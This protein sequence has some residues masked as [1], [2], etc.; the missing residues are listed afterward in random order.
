MPVPEPA[1]PKPHIQ[2]IPFIFGALFVVF[3]VLTDT[4]K[5]LKPIFGYQITAISTLD[6]DVCFWVIGIYLIGMVCWAHYRQSMLLAPAPPPKPPR[7]TILTYR[8][9]VI[10]FQLD[11]PEPEELNEAET[12][13]FKQRSDLA[14][15]RL[16]S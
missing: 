4:T 5:P 12:K 13:L 15:N 8:K 2:I 1:Q 16:R 6:L 14:E 9:T 10:V 11:P 3:G 7:P